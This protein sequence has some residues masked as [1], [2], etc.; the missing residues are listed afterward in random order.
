MKILREFEKLKERRKDNAMIP[1]LELA[2][3]TCYNNVKIVFMLLTPT[4]AL[5]ILQMNQLAI[6]L[7][8]P[9]L[10][11][12]KWQ[13]VK[14]ERLASCHKFDVAAGKLFTFYVPAILKVIVSSPQNKIW[15]VSPHLADEKSESH[16]HNVACSIPT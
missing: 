10:V 14:G 12:K 2:W 11:C 13:P 15:G 4:A 8:N 6:T 1:T 5:R 3:I 9:H 16:S 7:F